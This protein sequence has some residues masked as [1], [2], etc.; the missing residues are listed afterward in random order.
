MVHAHNDYVQD[1]PFLLAYARGAGSIEADVFLVNN[2]L[3]VAHTDKEITDDRTLEGL[4]LKPLA[5]KIRSLNGAAYKNSLPLMLFIDQKTEGLP[6]LQAL[7]KLLSEYPS[8]TQAKNLTITISGN[9][10]APDTWKQFPS[11][12]HF[13]GRPYVT[14]TKEQLE[15]IALIS[16]DFSHYSVWNGKGGFVQAEL[17]KVKAV[18]EQIHALGKKFRF[19]GV[20]DAVTAWITFRKLGIDYIGTDNVVAITD[21]IKHAD[22]NIYTGTEYHISEKTK[23]NPTQK[24]AKNIILL[25]GDGMG[26]AQIYGGY[27]ANHASLNLFS[28]PVV[29][30]SI[31]RSADAYITDSAA[32]ATAMACGIKTRN[33]AIAVDTTGQP[34]EPI[35]NILNR[36]K[37]KTAV[38]SCGNITDATPAAF[39]G[40]V[41]DRSANEKIALDFLTSPVDILIGAGEKYF[42]QRQDHQDIFGKLK[43]NGYTVHRDI[44]SMTTA[45]S[46]RQVIIN[47]AF[48]KSIKDGRGDFLSASLQNSLSVLAK[49]KSN[50]FIMAEGAQI[51]HGGHANDVSFIIREM[52]DFDNAVGTAMRYVDEHPETLLVVTADH[53]TGGLS[54]LAGDTKS[55]MVQGDFSTEDHTG[56]PVMVFAYGAGAAEFG[57]VYQNTEIFHKM[58]RAVNAKR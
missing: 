58:L 44:A 36:N 34:A 24:V 29:G 39:Y 9:Q 15:R 22:R 46:F 16:D 28:M 52:L 33:R 55:G 1:V 4:Y 27:T 2:K 11:Y 14:Y 40:H 35:T 45:G 49:S 26:L 23:T 38:I 41:T 43:Q 17:Q 56:I 47:D 10:P 37:F 48:G 18:V 31:T 51:D 6:T 8:I 21:F 13:D 50:F 54:L 5:E 42:N 25:I 20:P 32:G 7:V 57:G 19:W 12:I 53:E 3:Y 30:L